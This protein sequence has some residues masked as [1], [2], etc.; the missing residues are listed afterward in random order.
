V[1]GKLD[2]VLLSVPRVDLCRFRLLNYHTFRQL[3]PLGRTVAE[4]ASNLDLVHAEEEL[5]DRVRDLGKEIAAG[6]T[7]AP[8]IA[9]APAPNLPYVLL[10]GNTRAIA[11]LSASQQDEVEVLAVYE[12]A[13]EGWEF[14]R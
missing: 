9:V 13:I 7:H 8:L 6:A 10:D 11:Y 12:P 1:G 5:N 4:A 14:Y 2:G 3:A